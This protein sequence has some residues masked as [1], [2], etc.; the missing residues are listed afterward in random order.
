MMTCWSETGHAH[1]VS[2]SGLGDMCLTPFLPFV[3]TGPV[4]P[5]S[6][7]SELRLAVASTPLRLVFTPQSSK[8]NALLQGSMNAR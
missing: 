1:A 5:G 4:F 6:E 3:G 8:G 2:L 7:K